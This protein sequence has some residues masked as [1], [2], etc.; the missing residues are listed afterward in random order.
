MKGKDMKA[1][2]KAWMDRLAQ[3]LKE[4]ARWKAII[5][6]KRKMN[7]MKWWSSVFVPLTCYDT[8]N[9]DGFFVVCTNIV[10]ML[11]G[12][13][14]VFIHK[15][16]RLWVALFD[17]FWIGSHW[18]NS[19]AE[20]GLWDCFGIMI[21]GIFQL[22]SHERTVYVNKTKTNGLE[23]MFITTIPLWISFLGSTRVPF[24]HLT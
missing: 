10:S 14:T 17:S 1:T 11:Y 5:S 22:Q 3:E 20:A 7:Y 2:A 21:W 13:R 19:R 23:K 18:W 8:Y 16:G 15:T 9:I 4:K 24:A 12:K 6:G